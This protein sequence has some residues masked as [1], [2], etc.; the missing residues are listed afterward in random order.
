MADD[1]GNF[2][3][4][5][6]KNNLLQVR[7]TEDGFRRNFMGYADINLENKIK[8]PA[9]VALTKNGR[10]VVVDCDNHRILLLLI[11]SN[12]FEWLVYY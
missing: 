2:V 9:G 11:L 10:I 12:I 3:V 7:N 8:R 1:K 4:V 5:D 6:L